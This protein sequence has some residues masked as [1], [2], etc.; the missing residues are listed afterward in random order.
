MLT[1]KFFDITQSR[2]LFARSVIIVITGITPMF[3]RPSCEEKFIEKA[4]KNISAQFLCCGQGCHWSPASLAQLISY[5]SKRWLKNNWWKEKIF[6]NILR[7]TLRVRSTPTTKGE[8]IRRSG[9]LSSLWKYEDV[10]AK[11]REEIRPS[12]A[13]C[14]LLFF[15]VIA[16]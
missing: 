8:E 4:P 2:N 1:D 14:W 7:L 13:R 5:L 16:S 12:K 10:F 15:I 9:W 6:E 3:S 11:Q